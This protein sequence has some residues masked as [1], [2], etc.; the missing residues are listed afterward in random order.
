MYQ[1]LNLYGGPSVGKSVMASEI[2]ILCKKK[3]MKVE[4]VN[5]WIK[6]WAWEKYEPKG[7]DALYV[8]AKQVRAEERLLRQGVTVITD[9]PIRMQLA[10]CLHGAFSDV[11]NRFEERY[12]GF[13]V[14]LKRNFS[15]KGE[16]RYQTEEEALRKDDEIKDWWFS[17]GTGGRGIVGRP[18][19][20]GEA[21]RILKAW[22][23]CK[24]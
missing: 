14:L 16:G 19:F 2:F 17:L 6:M 4:L 24:L 3:G 9:S 11:S 23:D 10:Y 12:K 21:E 5:E 22:E 1:R 8:L 20:E 15:Y 7:F 18:G 13:H